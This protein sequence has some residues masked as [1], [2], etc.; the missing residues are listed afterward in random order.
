[1]QYSNTRF[2]DAELYGC[3]IDPIEPAIAGQIR[4]FPINRHVPW[5]G[6]S[7]SSTTNQTRKDENPAHQAI[8]E[9]VT[10][11]RP[12]SHAWRTAGTVWS[13]VKDVKEELVFCYKAYRF[14]KTFQLLIIGLG[15]VFDE[16]WGGKWGDLYSYFRW[17]VL[18]RLAGTPLVCLSVG[19]EEINTRLAKLFCRTTLSLAAYRSFRDVES[20]KKVEAI[21]VAGRATC[22]L[23]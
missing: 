19:V 21:G 2:P 22:F 9:R 5:L 10:R 23:T 3:C 6:K 14:V 13:K 20:K 12:L 7:R 15:G 17:A 4:A 8:R 1:M 11:T 18:A 16:V